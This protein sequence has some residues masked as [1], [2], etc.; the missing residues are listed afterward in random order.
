MA[1]RFL[2]CDVLGAEDGEEVL[3]DDALDATADGCGSPEDDDDDLG[4]LGAGFISPSDEN[5]NAMVALDFDVDPFA[6][7][8]GGATAVAGHAL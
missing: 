1:L 2:A 3:D 4:F 5:E 8:G 7:G 6:T